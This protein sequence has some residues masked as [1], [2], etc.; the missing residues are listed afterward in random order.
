MELGRLIKSEF[1]FSVDNFKTLEITFSYFYST[2]KDKNNNKYFVQGSFN[3]NLTLT[4]VE[5]FKSFY[6]NALP[7]YD[8]A[9]GICDV[10]IKEINK[11]INNI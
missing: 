1:I 8:T 2:V 5:A 4:T 6:T 3:D 9:K 7:S 11:K 10:L